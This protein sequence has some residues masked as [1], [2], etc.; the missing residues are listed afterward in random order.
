MGYG[1]DCIVLHERILEWCGYF[2]NEFRVTAKYA[3]ALQTSLYALSL[4]RLWLHSEF[5]ASLTHM[6]RFCVIIIKRINKSSYVDKSLPE[7]TLKYVYKVEKYKS[8]A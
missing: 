1:I 2:I 7:H 8:K 4:I 5:Q 3:D 6:I